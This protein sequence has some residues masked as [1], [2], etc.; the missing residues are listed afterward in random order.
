MEKEEIKV[1]IE[2]FVLF[3]KER[4]SLLREFVKEDVHG[5]LIFQVSFLG[6]ESLAKLLYLDERDSTKRFIKLLS[7]EIGEK[8]ATLYASW[9]HALIHQGFIEDP[10]TTLEN[11][12][13]EETRFLSYSKNV[14]R[15]SVEY[16]PGSMVEIYNHLIDYFNN[17]FKRIGKKEIT[18]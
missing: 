6:F 15:S 10:W 14:V 16:P 17:Y 11:W 2:K 8:D 7:I 18:I 1:N 5:K 9:R 4:V 3:H 13:K 12:E